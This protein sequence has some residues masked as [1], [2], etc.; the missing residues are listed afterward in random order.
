MSGAIY[1]G[2]PAPPFVAAGV[3]G[4]LSHGAN[5]AG[6]LHLSVIT[7][8]QVDRERDRCRLQPRREHDINGRSA[9]HHNAHY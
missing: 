1:G 5:A 6:E 9:P 7:A 4:Q 3:G 8:D 2:R